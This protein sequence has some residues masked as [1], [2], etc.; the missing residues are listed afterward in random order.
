MIY[1]LQAK[2]ESELSLARPFSIPYTSSSPFK[3]VLYRNPIGLYDTTTPET[4]I[5]TIGVYAYNSLVCPETV[6]ESVSFVLK[7]SFRSKGEG[8]MQLGIPQISIC[9]GY[10]VR[11][12][13]TIVPTQIIAVMNEVYNDD[14]NPSECRP[15]TLGDTPNFYV[16]LT[17]DAAITQDTASDW[18]RM[19]DY[20]LLFADGQYAIE[21]LVTPSF[22]S[23]DPLTIS[24]TVDVLNQKIVRAHSLPMMPLNAD[25]TTTVSDIVFAFSAVPPPSQLVAQIDTGASDPM[26]TKDIGEN[27]DDGQ[28]ILLGTMGEYSMSLR[29]LIKRFVHTRDLTAG[30]RVS[31][32]PADFINYDSEELYSTVPIG[33]RIWTDGITGATVPESWLNLISNL[34]RFA[35]GSVAQKVFLGFSDR[36]TTSLNVTDVLLT[37]FGTPES[38][39]S[40]VQE[41]V[42]NN[43]LEVR[44][45]YYGQNRARVIGDQ[46][47]GLTAK[48]SILVSGTG[49]RPCYEAAGDDFNMWFMVGPPI[50]RPV[51]VN[52]VPVPVIANGTRSMLSTL[53]R[54]ALKAR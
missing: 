48:S 14:I 21:C 4:H 52:P 7:H 24:L 32:T 43:A 54:L 33:N 39:P 13:P 22:S 37:E 6:A 47:R 49:T 42:I 44:T 29:P 28:R 25:V 35:A 40:F 38:D 23:V 53:D 17:G 8:A 19:V 46:V 31:Y 18:D 20:D 50:M 16:T 10:A 36:A 51:D 15:G 27:S 26:V 34:Y 11:F 9:G 12:D 1:D 30:T 2:E 41:G 45:P 5:G 3:K